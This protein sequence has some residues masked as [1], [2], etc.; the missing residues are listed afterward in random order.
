MFQRTCIKAHQGN[1]YYMRKSRYYV[2][3][4]VFYATT[5][6]HW[7]V[8]TDTYYVMLPYL[9]NLSKLDDL[10]FWMAHIFAS[11]I[12]KMRVWTIWHDL[13]V[14]AIPLYVYFLEA[15]YFYG[16][17]EYQKNSYR[18]WQWY[19]IIFVSKW[20]GLWGYFKKNE[21]NLYSTIAFWVQR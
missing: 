17:K 21:R 9:S 16:H 7:L 1:S 6:R 3:M 11:Q 8:H 19:V 2:L 20:W 12:A 4:K 15:R 5:F 10:L 18:Q 14:V 13:W